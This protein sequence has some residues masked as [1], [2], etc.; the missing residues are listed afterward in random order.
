M[1]IV[2]GARGYIASKL[3]YRLE[4]PY[5][6]I[7]LV[8]TAYRE[9]W[10]PE[11][12]VEAHSSL[13]FCSIQDLILRLKSL[14]QYLIV[15]RKLS[16]LNIVII[17]S[18]GFSR[19]GGD[20]KNATANNYGVNIVIATDI[21][22]LMNS[23]LTLDNVKSMSLI[24]LSTNALFFSKC[25][26]AYENSKYAQESIFLNYFDSLKDNRICCSILR[27]SDVFGDTHYHPS[28]LVNLVI[29]NSRKGIQLPY[30]DKSLIYRPIH[31]DF[32]V[33]QVIARVNASSMS[34]GEIVTQSLHSRRWYKVRELQQVA[35]S[36]AKRW[37][38]QRYA[39][40]NFVY[41]VSALRRIRGTVGLKIKLMSCGYPRILQSS[42]RTTR[43]TPI[44]DDSNFVE[45]L[46][47][48]YKS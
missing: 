16:D 10:S 23:I 29:D 26:A 14:V 47:K 4:D 5:C 18:S 28:K 21:V 27:L 8:D 39:I 42:L 40:R 7:V 46:A 38:V 44:Y 32:V 33:D 20:D 43:F 25:P 37:K 15:E 2:I 36:E 3:L 6:P 9:S 30:I 35:L 11:G 31:H 22:I 12:N 48:A 1:I 17:N 41:F 34:H 13:N 19:R 24:H 45:Y